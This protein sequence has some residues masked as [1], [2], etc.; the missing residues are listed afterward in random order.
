MEYKAKV[1][2]KVIAIEYKTKVGEDIFD[3]YV[4][5]MYFTIVRIEGGSD[6][7]V[8]AHVMLVPGWHYD[9]SVSGSRYKCVVDG[10][11]QSA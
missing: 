3:G 6:I 1:S 9:I 2:G 7:V 11:V 4:P 10:K 5:V 8:P